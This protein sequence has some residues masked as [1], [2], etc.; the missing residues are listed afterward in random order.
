VVTSHGYSCE[1]TPCAI[2]MPRKSQFTATLTKPGYK[3]ATITVSNKVKGGGGAAMAGNLLA[4]GI[5]GAG[6]DASNGSMLD[7]VPNPAH[8]ALQ[9][10]LAG[11]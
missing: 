6:V 8:V 7:L 1:A 3:A 11:R 10:E 2:K 4:G 9:R 5:I